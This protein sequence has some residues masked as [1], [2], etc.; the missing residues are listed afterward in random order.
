MPRMFGY[1][2]NPLS[3]F[4]CYGPDDRLQSV[5]YEVKNTFG[6]QHPYVLPAEPDPDGAVRHDQVKEFFVSPFIGMD[7]VYR[8]TIRPPGAR[9]ALRI[10]QADARGDYL[11]ATQS[12]AA[13][14]LSDAT[15]ARIALR[16]PWAMFK[17]IA[18]I[19]WQALRLWIKG[20][21]FLGYPGEDR[22]I[23]PAGQTHQA[24][25][26]ASGRH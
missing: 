16:T 4:F 22:V 2:F 14:P 17:V 1:A 9:L 12:G 23:Q 19:H 10:K 3:V 26:T 5:I 7:Q 25:Q 6:D 13:V 11:I 18:A 15:L 21:K 8:F 20:A 24:A